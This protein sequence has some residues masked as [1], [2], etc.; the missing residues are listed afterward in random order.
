MSLPIGRDAPFRARRWLVNRV[1]RGRSEMWAGNEVFGAV[2]VKPIFTGLE[3]GNNRMVRVAGMPRCVL[4]RGIIATSNVT[5]L[6]A[7]A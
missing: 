7:A 2:I 4:R 1:V 3:A 6:G 5:A